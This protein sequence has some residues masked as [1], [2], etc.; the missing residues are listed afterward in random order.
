MQQ[1]LDLSAMEKEVISF[2]PG[3]KTH[4]VV[5]K[6]KDYI[7]AEKPVIGDFSDRLKDYETSD[8]EWE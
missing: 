5:M 6:L 7:D 3:M 4:T 8:E 2:T 1:Y